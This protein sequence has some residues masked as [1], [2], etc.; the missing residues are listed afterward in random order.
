ML[1]PL[2]TSDLS[3]EIP[4]ALAQHSLERTQ[5]V[6]IAILCM[7]HSCRGNSTLLSKRPPRGAARRNYAATALLKSF[8]TIAGSYSVPFFSIPKNILAIRAAI[9][10]ID[11]IFFSGFSF[12]V[13]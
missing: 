11:C 6:Q 12:R 8:I 5:S 9:A 3:V 10:I 7:T 13:V 2:L 4:I 1:R